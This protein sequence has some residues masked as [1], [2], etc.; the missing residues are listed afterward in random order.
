MWTLWTLTC[1]FLIGMCLIKQYAFVSW[2]LVTYTTLPVPP[3]QRSWL[4]PSDHSPPQQWCVMMAASLV[5]T[6]EG[7]ICPSAAS[8]MEKWLN[9]QRDFGITG[10]LGAQS[11]NLDLQKSVSSHLTVGI[12][13]VILPIFRPVST[14]RYLWAVWGTGLQRYCVG[15]ALI[16]VQR[17]STLWGHL[18]GSFLNIGKGKLCSG[19]FPGL[20]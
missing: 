6:T 5:P 19:S 8:E 16:P 10:I 20:G 14:R 12:P 13:N 11:Q 3:S 15:K 1:V 2:L 9:V 7:H 4:L 18:R 17:K